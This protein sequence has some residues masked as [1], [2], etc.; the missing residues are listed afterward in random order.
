L[1]PV[2]K[3]SSPLARES[4]EIAVLFE[5]EH[6]LALDKP[7]GLLISPNP[8]QPDRPSL[9]A[10]LHDGISKKKAWAQQR[11]LS[12]LM[13]AHRLDLETSGVLLLARSKP[14]LAKMADL[15]SAEKSSKKFVALVHGVPHG[16][17]FEVDAKLAPHPVISGLMQVDPKLGKRSRTLC[18]VLEQFARYTLLKCELVT[19]RM[20]QVRIHLRHA[21]FPVVG[22]TLYGGRPLMLSR[23]KPHFRLKPGHTERP[24]IG[25]AAVH[26][27]EFTL[28]HPV[29]GHPLIITAPWPKDLTV[30][31]KYLRSYAMR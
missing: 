3:L 17:R 24:L 28:P 14:V 30:A 6:L 31:L 21:G 19:D 16:E 1:S 7:A 9:L 23:L 4:W 25:R 18:Q 26:A 13:N 15:F 29:T 8:N 20:H 5:D 2:I 12:Y 11:A 22:D 27:E 10:M